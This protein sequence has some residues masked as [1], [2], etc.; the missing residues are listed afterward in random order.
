MRFLSTPAHY[1]RW[2][3]FCSWP[4]RYIFDCCTVKGI[5]CLIFY[6]GIVILPS[7]LT[8]NGR[9]LPYRTPE[10]L[11]AYL[12]PHPCQRRH[13]SSTVTVMLSLRD[14]TLLVYND[15][16]F[17][18]R[19]VRAAQL[20]ADT[21]KRA[22]DAEVERLRQEH[23]ARQVRTRGRGEIWQRAMVNETDSLLCVW[24]ALLAL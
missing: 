3:I 20:T 15:R 7:P 22:A 4:V 24:H 19:Q 12:P 17:E 9:F 8:R 16:L 14:V 13:L 2:L 23:G 18:P 11:F 6:F 10:V 5:I 1:E 21:F